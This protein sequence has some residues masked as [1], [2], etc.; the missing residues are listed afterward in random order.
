MEKLP[1]FTILDYK[2]LLLKIRNEGF[3][4]ESILTL[5]REKS[6]SVY[7]RHDIDFSVA[8]TIAMAEAE[9]QFAISSTYY[10]LLTGPYNIFHE[11]SSL[12][13][14]RLVELGHEIGLHYDLKA[15]PETS[16]AA[17]SHLHKEIDILEFVAGAQVKTI[18]MHEPFRGNQDILLNQPGLINPSLY[19]KNDSRLCYISDSCRAWR[20]DN[21]LRFLRRETTENRLQLN[22]HP[23]LWLADKKQ[24][25]MKYLDDT[26]IPA[27]FDEG[28]RYYSE[29]VRTVWLTHPAVTNGSV[30]EVEV[31][32]SCDVSTDAQQRQS[33]I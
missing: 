4:T 5:D 32:E 15:Y 17:T 26:L 8:H 21:L 33:K 29:V 1:N 30:D 7:I 3:S 31:E 12:A 10:I 13:I 2:N 19:Q 24:N 9:N 27:I 18:V 16:G 14:R 25:R 6:D 23:E 22:I 11:K 28:T 20:D